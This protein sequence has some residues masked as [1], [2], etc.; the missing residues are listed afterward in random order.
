MNIIT[1]DSYCGIDTRFY[2]IS[3]IDDCSERVLKFIKETLPEDYHTYEIY[4]DVLERCS[5][6]LRLKILKTYRRKR[7]EG[8]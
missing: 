2:D 1:S 4:E 3:K 7:K 5:G 6:K 8:E